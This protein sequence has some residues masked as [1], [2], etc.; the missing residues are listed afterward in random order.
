MTSTRKNRIANKRFSKVNEESP[1]KDAGNSSKSR[2]RKRKLL[3]MSGSQWSKEELQRFYEA[4]RKYGKEWKKVAS[5]LRNRSAEMVESL[6]NMNRAYLS[7]PEGLSSVAGLIAMMT[8]HYN[9][10]EVTQGSESERESNDGVSTSQKPQRRRGKLQMSVAKGLNGPFLDLLQCPP[11]PSYGCLSLLKKRRSGGGRP[12]PV[13]KRTP[14]FPVSY[15]YSKD[16]REK[17]VLASK[18]GLKRDKDASDDDVAHVAA[19]ALAEASHRGGSPQVSRTPSRSE[20]TRPSPVQNGERKH[21]ESEVASTKVIGSA[22]YEERFEG[23]LGSREADSGDFSREATEGAGRVEIE[24]QVKKVQGKKPKVL[25]MGNDHFDDIREACSGTEEGLAL[26]TVKDEI[27]TE[28]TNVNVARSSP[29]GP[30]KRSRQ[31]FSR[32]ESSAL[33]ALQTLADISLNYHMPLS[34]GDSESSIRIKE[35]KKENNTYV[36]SNVSEAMSAN[37]RREKPKAS[38]NKAKGHSSVVEVDIN[39]PKEVDKDSSLNVSATA[40]GKQQHYQATSRIQKRKRKSSTAKMLKSEDYGD[41]ILS[42]SQRAE[43]A[44]EEVK[45]ITSK[46]KRISQTVPLTKQGASVRQPE[47]SSDSDARRTGAPLTESTA[48]P[49]AINQ[50]YSQTK[51]R[52]RRKMG[53]QKIFQEPRSSENVGNV[54]PT[55]LSR[56]V[57]DKALDLKNGLSHCLLSQLLRR[58]CVFEWFYSAID[59]P[60]F[61]KSEFVEYLNHVGLGHIPRLTRVEWGV[62]RSSLGK[63]RRF[64]KQFL[65]EEREK[66]EQ[67]RESVRTH[68]AELRAGTREGLATDLARPLSVGQRVIACHPRTREIHDGSVLTVDRNRCRV[69]FD[70]PE[71]GVEFVKD[72]DCMPL[73]PLENMPEALRRQNTAVDRFR[74]NINWIKADSESEEWRSG[75]SIKLHQSE[76]LEKVDGFCQVTSSNYPMNTLLSPAKGDTIDE[77]LQAKAAANEVA[78]AQATYSQPYTFAQIQAREADI[79]ALSELNRALDKKEA[80]VLELKHMNE[81]VESKHK[82]E[83]GMGNQKGGDSFT[84]MDHHFKQQYA[85]VLLQLK[86]AND[87]VSSALV[88]LRQRNTFHGNSMPQWVSRPMPN[89]GGCGVPSSSFDRPTFISQELGSHV[90]GIVESSRRKAR[91]MVHEAMEVMSSSKEAEDALARVGEADSTNSQHPGAD[92]GLPAVGSCTPDT[93]YGTAAFQD[94]PTCLLE[95]TAVHAPSSKHN[96]SDGNELQAPSE[97]IS[98]CVATLLMIQTCTERPPDEVVQILDMAVTSLQPCCPQNLD[99]YIEIQKCMGRVKHQILARIPTQTGIL[100]TELQSI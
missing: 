66:L 5:V 23:S 28:V 61:A 71:L 97:L 69:Q 29:K 10:L 13:G 27:E 51:Y 82:N 77:V 79:K 54:R 64:S 36:K 72:I 30:R 81:E 47:F 41:S 22:L 56:M 33:D 89:L 3:D 15:P 43:A 46:A 99:I 6:Y 100:T 53:L 98:A 67:Y 60:W 86:A 85:M 12:I 78:S 68:Y 31:L 75:G 26:R 96:N 32:D 1:D 70:W 2:L 91:T 35:E 25:A 8:D 55:K 49:S 45:R 38:K 88:C 17:I 95:T 84:D 90:I 40:E 62:I 52:S 34:A 48:H 87:Q 50:I 58:W 19:L 74:E 24:K 14:R 20:H 4:Y 44:T 57:H 21:D 9:M 59:Y 11:A 65:Q 73:N 39:A 94:Q 16:E 83:E 37:L 80:L 93:R 42:E 63:P 18:R 76:N 7:L 92:S